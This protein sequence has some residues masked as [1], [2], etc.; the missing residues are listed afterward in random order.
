MTIGTLRA[1][2]AERLPGVPT[3][4]RNSSTYAAHGSAPA[5]TTTT[6]PISERERDRDDRDEDRD[7]RCRARPSAR[8]DRGP[9]RRSSADRRS[10]G[11]RGA[12]IATG[13]TPGSG[14]SGGRSG[15]ASTPRGRTPAI[16]RPTFISVASAPAS[17][18]TIRPRY[19]TTIRSASERI[20]ARSALISSTPAPSLRRRRI[21]PRTNSDAAMSM[22]RVGCAATMSGCGSANSR[23]I[24]TRCA[25]PPESVRAGRDGSDVR[26]PNRVDEVARPAVDGRHV[27][28]AAL[29][30][31]AAGAWRPEQ[32][33]VGDARL[34]RQP[35]V[36][37][38]LRARRR[39]RTPAGRRRTPSVTS[40][41]AIATDPRRGRLEARDHL[42][43]LR[44]AVA[45]DAGH[46]DDL[47]AAHRQRHVVE[48]GRAT[49]RAAPGPDRRAGPRA[50]RTRGTP[51]ARP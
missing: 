24:T 32:Q 34:G 8:P 40:R 30:R 49:R 12:P 37:A 1:I 36:I 9:S 39:A 47:A 46:A 28:Q 2:V 25:F 43:Q 27:E 45:G 33:V 5:R 7:E 10:P 21:S 6:P 31:P 14:A 29:R 15:V 23:A 13:A 4:P 41:P 11:T 19:R 44:L 38:V 17:S 42:G 3:A 20:S 50:A 51:R 16:S 48:A 22:P 18:P 26:M 35:A